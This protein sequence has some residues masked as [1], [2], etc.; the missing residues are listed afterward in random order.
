MSFI[1]KSTAHTF[2]G[3]YFRKATPHSIYWTSF[4]MAAQYFAQENIARVHM[5]EHGIFHFEVEP[6][7]KDNRE[8]FV[9]AEQTNPPFTPNGKEITA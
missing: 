8:A 3:L 6:A 2:N 5:I 7:H 9:P 1:V 4:P